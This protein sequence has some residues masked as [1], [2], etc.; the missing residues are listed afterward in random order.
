VDAGRDA[1]AL[2][3]T[4]SARATGSCA[5]PV[6]IA[7]GDVRGGAMAGG[8]A[9]EV[10][11]KGANPMMPMH[12]WHGAFVDEGGGANGGHARANGFATA[13]QAAA[14]VAAGRAAEGRFA[15]SATGPECVRYW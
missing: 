14:V 7:G 3:R 6:A 8:L 9:A 13:S 4:A 10:A 2:R 5:G 1:S 15:D 11:G 12:P